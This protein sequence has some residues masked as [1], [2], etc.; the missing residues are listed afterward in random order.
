MASADRVVEIERDG[1]KEIDSGDDT[2]DCILCLTLQ[3]PKLLSRAL[4][5]VE[6][7]IR[8]INKLL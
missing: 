6:Q 8:C 1:E 3:P 5:V 2:A 7:R 4:M